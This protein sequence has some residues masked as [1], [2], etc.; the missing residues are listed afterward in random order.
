MPSTTVL[1]EQQNTWLL[2]VRMITHQSK[3]VQL[4]KARNGESKQYWTAATNSAFKPD[5]TEC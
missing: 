4:D 1:D 2:C 5:S 3:S